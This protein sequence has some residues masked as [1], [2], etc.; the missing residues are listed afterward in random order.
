RVGELPGRERADVRRHLGGGAARNLLTLLGV[1]RGLQPA[2]VRTGFLAHLPRCQG[3]GGSE[4]VVE[5]AGTW[6]Y[7]WRN[8]GT[9]RSGASEAVE[10]DRHVPV[11]LDRV[12][13]LLAPALD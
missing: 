1:R 6:S 4:R 8:H 9:R 5:R 7:G 11:L 2:P 3:A 12:V 13:E 10:A